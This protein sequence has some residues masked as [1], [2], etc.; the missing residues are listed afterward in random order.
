MAGWGSKEQPA[1]NHGTA[2]DTCQAGDPPQFT[3]SK[4]L[5]T[6]KAPLPVT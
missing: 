4:G 6:P 3:R 2:A 1:W 5:L